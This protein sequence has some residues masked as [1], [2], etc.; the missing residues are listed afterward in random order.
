L[1]AKR[2]VKKL[3]DKNHNRRRIFLFQTPTHS[4]I[5]DHGIAE[6]EIQFLKKS[7][8]NDQLVEINQSIQPY[9]VKYVGNTI[10]KD[11]ILLLHGGG[12]LGNQYMYE[13][14]TRRLTVAAFP[15]NKMILFPQTIYYSS[16]EKG[17]A[18]LTK[19]KEAFSKSTR[20]TLIAREETSFVVMRECFPNAKILLTPDIVLSMDMSRPKLIREGLLMVMRSDQERILNEENHL[21]LKELGEKYF[22]KIISSDMHYSRGVAGSKGRREVLGFKFKQFKSAKLVITD[23]LHGMVFA[24]ITQTPCIAF[25]NYNQKVAGTY[26]WIKKLNYVRFVKID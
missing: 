13:E 19:T 11:D 21:F 12:N 25:S 15:D 6:A 20:L 9:F 7:F 17:H 3:S 10:R 18:E 23:R 16:D 5:G 22:D 4:N 8:P 24:A 26:D 14:N 1:E 2:L